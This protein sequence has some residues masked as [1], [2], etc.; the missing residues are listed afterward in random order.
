MPTV[1]QNIRVGQIWVKV[2]TEETYLVTK[3]YTEVLSTVAMLRPTD[4]ATESMIRVRIEKRDGQ[5]FLPGFSM[6]QE[7]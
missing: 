6:A 7:R 5:A 3:L 1:E 4:A 2:G